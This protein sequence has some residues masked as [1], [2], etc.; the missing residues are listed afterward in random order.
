MNEKVRER[1]I[2]TYRCNPQGF[3]DKYFT[4]QSRAEQSRAE[5]SRAEQ[6]RAEQRSRNYFLILLTVS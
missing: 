5:Q 6:S 2:E 3:K 4:E 1:L